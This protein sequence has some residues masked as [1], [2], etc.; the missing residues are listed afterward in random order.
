MA[1]M[2]AALAD[3][4]AL[5]GVMVVIAPSAFA[6]DADL[7]KQVHRIA[8]PCV[9]IFNKQDAAGVAALF[10]TNAIVVNSSGP[11][12]DVVKF[13]EG[14]FKAGLNADRHHRHAD[15]KTIPIGFTHVANDQDQPIQT[16]GVDM[17]SRIDALTANFTTKK[18]GTVVTTGTRVIAK[19]GKTMT[20]SAKG[21]FESTWSTTGSSSAA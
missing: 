1:A 14:L 20:L 4:F 2:K 6:D 10:A 21:T 8:S 7:K 15:G 3:A 12:T 9:E 18:D 11:Q 16:P 13:A 19:D 17:L 5:L